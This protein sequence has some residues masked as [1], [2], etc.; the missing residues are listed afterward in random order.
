M[1]YSNLIIGQYQWIV[2][3]ERRKIVKDIK[4]II[5]L[6][7]FFYQCTDKRDSKE[8]FTVTFIKSRLQRFLIDIH[9]KEITMGEIAFHRSFF[10]EIHADEFNDIIKFFYYKFF[11]FDDSLFLLDCKIAN[12]KYMKLRNIFHIGFKTKG[13]MKY[14][15]HK[16]QRHHFE[17]YDNLVFFYK[18]NINESKIESYS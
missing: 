15:I 12:V 16:F 8:L 1:A 9:K 4:I 14:Y 18:K 2:K 7:D 3:K 13:L 5:R 10:Q 17:Y 6:F 11:P